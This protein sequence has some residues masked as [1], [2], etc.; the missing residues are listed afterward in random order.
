MSGT[1]KKSSK[2]VRPHD[3]VRTTPPP[4]S[5]ARPLAAQGRLTRFFAPQTAATPMRITRATSKL[6]ALKLDAPE[7]EVKDS[8][9][10]E[11]DNEDNEAEVQVRSPL[12]FRPPRRFARSSLP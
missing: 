5:R 7:A 4:P 10:E 9:P 1:P 3:F 6:A 11:V 2:P 12:S 8:P